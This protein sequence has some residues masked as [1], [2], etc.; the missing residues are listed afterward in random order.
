VQVDFL[1]AKPE[2]P[3]LDW[4]ITADKRFESHPQNLGIKRN[5]GVFVFGRQHEMV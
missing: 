1:I 4:R 5:T 3:A 2:C